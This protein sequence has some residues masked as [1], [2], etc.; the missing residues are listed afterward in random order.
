M[1]LELTL[2]ALSVF[3]AALA[4]AFTTVL[5]VR[6]NKHLE[7]ERNASALLE[8]LSQ[9][10]DP[11]IVHAFE[12]LEGIDRRYP[13]DE[14]VRRSF[15]DSPD[16]RALL[17][18]A[19]YVETVACLARRGVLDPSLL[20]DAIGFSLRGY[21]ETIRAFVERLRRVRGYPLILENFEWLA[22]YSVAY[23]Q[24]P[25]PSG[26]NYDPNQFAGLDFKPWPPAKG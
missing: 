8:A 15:D 12:E 7:H 19:Q 18:V 4:L 14:T 2:S 16:D 9:L 5:L 11:A 17:L 24:G 21:W 22:M 20:A 26:P 23:R 25:R 6:Q 3:I 10:T 1:T 13:D